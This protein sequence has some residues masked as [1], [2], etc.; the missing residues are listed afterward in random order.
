MNHVTSLEP[1]PFSDTIKCV[2]IG[3]LSPEMVDFIVS[4]KPEYENRL[5]SN[6][7]ILF[8]ADRISHTELHK[9]DFMSD[10]EFETCF[11]DIPDIVSDP[12]YI[13][14]HPKDNSISFIKDY[15]GHVS[16]AIRVSITGNMAYRTMYPITDAQLTHYIDSG[17]AWKY[18][19]D[20]P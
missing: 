1:N 7:D 19:G 16:V 13:S 15:S 20:Q 2:S 14:V 5:S 17:F 8:W 11:A 3:R 4:R 6:K 9:N 18:P 10:I 12:D